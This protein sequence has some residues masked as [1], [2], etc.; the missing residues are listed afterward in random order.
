VTF[1]EKYQNEST[2][3]GKILIM[4]IYHT[5]M[6]QKYPK[7][8]T[9]HHTANDFGVSIGLTSEN[10]RLA[11]ALD[12]NPGLINCKSRADALDKLNKIF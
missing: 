12:T 3:Y 7:E 10:I 5:V 11:V 1:I 9:L 2:W 8:W 4:G 6:C